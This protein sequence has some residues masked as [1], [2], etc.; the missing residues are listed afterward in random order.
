LPQIPR[1]SGPRR[2]LPERK[3]GAIRSDQVT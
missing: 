2:R 1:R 3:P